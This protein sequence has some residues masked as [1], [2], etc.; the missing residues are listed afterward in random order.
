MLPRVNSAVRQ[1]AHRQVNEMALDGGFSGF[2]RWWPRAATFS[3]RELNGNRNMLHDRTC[4][5]AMTTACN[6]QTLQALQ[7]Q[8][9]AG[10]TRRRSVIIDINR[11]LVAACCMLT[12]TKMARA[13]SMKVTSPLLGL[14]DDDD[15]YNSNVNNEAALEPQNNGSSDF[16]KMCTVKISH[17]RAPIT[18]SVN[19]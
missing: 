9:D 1:S 13:L 6:R 16:A 5:V 18:N 8:M 11:T 2:R 10:K 4:A 12:R 17:K 14:Y 7:A 15:D 19:H 3:K